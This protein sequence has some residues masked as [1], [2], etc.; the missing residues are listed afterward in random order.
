MI[1]E[2]RSILLASALLLVSACNDRPLTLTAP[3]DTQPVSSSGYVLLDNLAP[4]SA[5]SASASLPASVRI[6]MPF[7]SQAPTG[8]WNDPYQEACEEA[9]LLLVFHYLSGIPLSPAI[10][11][12]DIRELVTWETEHGYPE[13]VT[14]A[15]L[16]SIA[17]E[18]YGYDA[19]IIEGTDL[20]IRR[21]EQELSSG[22]P[23]IVPLAGQDIGN[24][25]YSGDGP[26]YHMLV[27]NGYDSRNF[28]THDVGTRRGE[29]YAYKKEVI[30]DA[31]HD[32]T[33]SKETIRDGAKRALVLRK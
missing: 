14:V 8:D 26:P 10:M 7:A 27:I 15:E 18:K 33:G 25:Y 16:A 6:E 5:A 4:S 17:R 3:V 30:M 31:I 9:S 12:R 21:I 19:D 28:V 1:A 11:D 24:P 29:Y 22:N 23:V 20:T 32:W 2:M 13:D